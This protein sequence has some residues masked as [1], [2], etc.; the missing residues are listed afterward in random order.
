MKWN[1]KPVPTFCHFFASS[2]H[3][4]HHFLS[5]ALS[6]P[7]C[8]MFIVRSL[9]LSLSPSHLL[10]SF[11]SWCTFCDIILNPAALLCIYISVCLGMQKV[12]YRLYL[13]HTL[14]PFFSYLDPVS[15]QSIQFFDT[16]SVEL[17][18]LFVVVFHLFLLCNCCCCCCCCS[19]CV[20]LVHRGYVF[21]LAIFCTVTAKSVLTKHK[22]T[23]HC[24][25]F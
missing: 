21:Y 16:Y 20:V 23:T 5:L 25:R 22:A 19:L 14:L 11:N 2:C 13:T 10:S 8:D 18:V 3:H 7:L 4:H 17:C 12:S 24:K 1:E 6:L 15:R 9:T